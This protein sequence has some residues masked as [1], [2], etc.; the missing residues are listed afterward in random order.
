MSA[1]LMP[2]AI[3]RGMFS[4]IA[5]DCGELLSATDWPSHTGQA[6]WCSSRA[7]RADGELSGRDR[8]TS[9]TI[10]TTTTSPSASQGSLFCVMSRLLRRA[11]LAGTRGLEPDVEHLLRRGSQSA[12]HRDSVGGDH[13]GLRL[14]RRPESERCR[15]LGIDDN[16]P[17]DL[18]LSHVVAHRRRIV[19]DDDADH[20]EVGFVLVCVVERLERRRLLPARD[21]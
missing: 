12:A 19:V 20:L 5:R 13:V 2:A 6:S 11:L 10:P 7:A 14:P 8:T 9:T 1:S 21:A 18:L 15:T 3:W 17:V 4:L 16:G